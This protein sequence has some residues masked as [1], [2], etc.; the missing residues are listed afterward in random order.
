MH[1]VCE[2]V[3]AGDQAIIGLTLE[4]SLHDSLH[5]QQLDK[6]HQKIRFDGQGMDWAAT[7]ITLEE[8]AESVR[9]RRCTRSGSH[10][11]VVLK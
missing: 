4:S 11:A 9:K 8:L 3:S 7:L 10:L 5:G 2:Q 6:G 1:A